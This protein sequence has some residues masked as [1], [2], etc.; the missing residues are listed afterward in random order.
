MFQ[1]LKFQTYFMEVVRNLDQLF[2][3]EEHDKS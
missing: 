1:L 3:E 2:S